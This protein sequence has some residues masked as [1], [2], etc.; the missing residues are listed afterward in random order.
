MHLK[1]WSRPEMANAVRDLSRFNANGSEDHIN[2]MYRVMQYALNIPHRGL[3][4]APLGEWDGNPDYE[5]E[6][7]GD[8]DASCKPCTDTDCSVGGCAVFLNGAPISKK[9]NVQQCTTLSVTEAELVSGSSCVQD[10]LFAMRVLESIGLKVKKP[11]KLHIDNKG[12]VDHINNWSTSGR[13]Q[14][15]SVRLSFLRKLKDA[16]IIAVEWCKSEDM[17]ADLFTKN[18]AGPLFK[19]H[20]TVFCGSD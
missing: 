1:C 15:V 4:L 3:T 7:S 16:G 9:T 14:H 6:I 2:A 17:V 8:A 19:T 18:L 20:T 5:F 11:M 12:A 13:M 10:M